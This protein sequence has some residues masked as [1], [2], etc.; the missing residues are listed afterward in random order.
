MYSIQVDGPIGSTQSLDSIMKQT[1]L[2]D[3]HTQILLEENRED[4]WTE[5][6]W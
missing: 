6:R 3:S 1:S 5:E 2:S 4:C